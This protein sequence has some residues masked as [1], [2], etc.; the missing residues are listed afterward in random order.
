MPAVVSQHTLYAL[1]K[2]R[3]MVTVVQA[4]K[5]RHGRILKTL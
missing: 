3:G 2:E 4:S 1:H 5:W